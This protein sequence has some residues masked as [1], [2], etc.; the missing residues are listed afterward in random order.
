ME[1]L[2]QLEQI[3]NVEKVN[4]Y[5]KMP[6]FIE[7]IFQVFQTAIESS[8]KQNDTRL[9]MIAITI[10]NYATKLANIYNI[11]LKNC[12]NTEKDSIN[13]IPIF[14]YIAINNIQLYDFSKILITDLDTE[15]ESDL[16]KFVLTHVYYL[17]Q[18]YNK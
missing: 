2:E 12:I 15:N 1:Q 9:K 4:K 7:S 3:I 16:E 6:E 17:T 10:Y 11:D 14:E 18:Q 8:V 5:D 13:L